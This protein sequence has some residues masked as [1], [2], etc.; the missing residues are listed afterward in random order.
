MK[1]L[2]D[3]A[4]KISP[5]NQVALLNRGLLSWQLGEIRDDQFQYFIKT[6]V[7]HADRELSRLFYILFKKNIQ[8][9][10]PTDSEKHEALKCLE[11]RKYVISNIAKKI[12]DHPDFLY[13]QK[14]LTSEELRVSMKRMKF[15]KC[16]YENDNEPRE[17][18]RV[19]LDP[20]F[21]VNHF[22]FSNN[23]VYIVAVSKKELVIVD[24]R[25]GAIMFN[26]F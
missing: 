18:Q 3:E 2:L 20:K 21:E 19:Q 10:M 17:N 4:I 6:K 24:S 11:R 14:Q 22:Y 13:D 15:M 1:R 9:N 25:T 12:F 26:K 16:V 7:Y 8:G 5:R 23:D